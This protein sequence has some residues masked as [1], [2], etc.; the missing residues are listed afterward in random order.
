MEM[1]AREVYGIESLSA[2]PFDTNSRPA[3]IGAKVAESL[4][5]GPAYHQRVLRAFWQ[6][7]RAIGK[8][9]VLIELAKEIRIPLDQF[10]AGLADPQYEALV[11]QDIRMAATYN[12]RG[13]PALIFGRKYLVPGA[14]PFQALEEVVK[15]ALE[16]GL[17]E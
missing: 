14:Q 17:G 11:D 10:E 1:I 7:A 9:E 12:L 16:E 2:G 3:L 8:P 4:G 6:E 13:V 15:Q 5:Y